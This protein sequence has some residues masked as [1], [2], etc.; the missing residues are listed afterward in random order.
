MVRKFQLLWVKA[1]G[2]GQIFLYETTGVS[3]D[4]GSSYAAVPRQPEARSNLGKNACA[5]VSNF[6]YHIF[7]KSCELEAPRR[8]FPDERQGFEFVEVLLMI[9]V[10]YS[11]D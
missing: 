1:A 10:G 3:I 9:L 4:V 6:L 2:A 8:D 7:S 11:Y 5:K